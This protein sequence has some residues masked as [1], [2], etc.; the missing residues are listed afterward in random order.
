[1]HWLW[2]T[3]FSPIGNKLVMA[4]TGAGFCAFLFVH[5]L[6]NWTV[7]RGAAAFEAYAALLASFGATLIVM[8]AGLFLV[9]C[10]H[11]GFG[12]F[13]AWR[14]RQARPVAYRGRGR[15]GGEK[16]LAR[17]MPLSGLGILAFVGMHLL[18]FRFAD[19]AA[20][21]LYES[22][23][24]I[25]SRPL[26]VGFYVGGL[27]LVFLH[28]SHGLWSLFQTVGWVHPKFFDGIRMLGWSFAVMMFLGF[29]VIPLYFL[30]S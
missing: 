10:F 8:E 23:V 1:M 30:F 7:F 17:T 2:K 16:W 3:L 22:V 20:I 21:G 26:M 14:N 6:G 5:L 27:F 13:L 18:H 29:S 19:P 11:V 15:L 9:A 25:F 12:L 4:V 24:L 28:L